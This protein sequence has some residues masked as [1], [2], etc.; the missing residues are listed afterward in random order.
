M[1]TRKLGPALAAG[2]TAV[3]KP[4]ELTPLTALA[5]C[6]IAKQ[7]GV[8]AGVVNCLTVGREEVQEVGAALCHSPE[9]RKLSFT[10][11]TAVGKW[12]Y[13]ECADTMKKLSME[14][15]GNAPF[16][17]FDDADLDVAVS[18]LMN[19]KFRYVLCS[20]AYI[21]INLF[22]SSAFYTHHSN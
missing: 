18:A 10:G 5:F 7:A 11:S 4:A 8:P 1:I 2:C 9:L 14:L 13:R 17:V 20:L 12:L 22:F 19:C 15:G 21:H 16:I 6:A 3:I